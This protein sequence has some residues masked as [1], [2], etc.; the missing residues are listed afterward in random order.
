[1]TNE[2]ERALS[3]MVLLLHCPEPPADDAPDL[4]YAPPNDDV[5]AIFK[6]FERV[7]AVAD[8]HV[9]EFS[10][11]PMDARH[12]LITWTEWVEQER[13]RAGYF[14]RGG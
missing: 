5:G 6:L 9:T 13:R 14:L 2:I 11:A 4:K 7:W 1:M 8:D 3:F 10:R 12:D